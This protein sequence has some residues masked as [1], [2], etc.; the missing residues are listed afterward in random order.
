M[1]VVFLGIDL[2]RNV[3]ALHGV[4]WQFA[5]FGCAVHAFSPGRLGPKPC[6]GV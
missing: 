2:A 4:A 6:G 1:T 3:F 5:G